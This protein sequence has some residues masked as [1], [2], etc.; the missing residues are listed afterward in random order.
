MKR[1]LIITLLIFII[2]SSNALALGLAPATKEILVKEQSYSFPIKIMNNQNEEF[3]AFIN[4]EGELSEYVSLSEETIIFTKDKDS[5]II[6]VNV[7]LPKI[8]TLPRGK[9]VVNIVIMQ[10]MPTG[11]Q[12]S[13]NLAVNF[14]LIITVPS[15]GHSL[16]MKF[17]TANFKQHQ[18]SNFLIE[19]TNTGTAN[20]VNSK[21]IIEIYDLANNKLETLTSESKMIRK[22]EMHA[23]NM[24][25]SPEL[26][27]G[28]YK[29]TATLIYDGQS[30]QQ[31]K[32]IHVGSPSIDITTITT[33]DFL[34]GG[35]AHF[36]LVLNS[37]W[38]EKIE[39]VFAEVVFMKQNEL[40]AATKTPSETLEPLGKTI[41]PV[42]W[43]TENQAPGLYKMIINL[44]YLGT[45]KS[46]TYDI[47]MTEDELNVLLPTGQVSG[48]KN[49]KA[50]SS[51]STT[52]LL[53]VLILF[54]IIM[55]AIII[56]KFMIK[57]K[58]K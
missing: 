16:D 5:E 15:E 40:L 44:N 55:N 25:W 49:K 13:A 27:N 48:S 46:H 35:V 23:Y 31:T 57:K 6:N 47:T 37:N 54:L 3:I 1:A 34:L 10:K 52:S 43:D 29:A 30:M 32:R 50:S 20:I 14:D 22:G 38:A 11:N 58:R 17:Y 18:Q 28:E 8:E 51:S 9:N 36:D 41:L 19:A 26:N 45:Q 56:Y 2:F 21:A 53:I 12:L 24:P 33:Y 7:D 4:V 42:Y 39:N